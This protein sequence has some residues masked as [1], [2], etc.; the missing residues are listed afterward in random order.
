MAVTEDWELAILEVVKGEAAREMALE[1]NQFN[2]PPAEGMQY[3]AFKS[4]IRYIGTEDRP[5]GVDDS[6]FRATGSANIRYPMPSV[7]DPS[8]ALDAYLYPGGEYEG[9][10]IQQ[11]AKDETDLMVIFEPT[12]S[13]D[14]SE[15][16]Y[17]ALEEGATLTVPAELA[18]IEPN[19]LGAD[20]ESAA[21]IGETVV[22]EDWEITIVESVRGDNAWAMVQN[23]NQFN[24]P[25][26][27]G[28]EYIA[29]K[30]HVRQIGTEDAYVNISDAEFSITGSEGTL[31]DLPPVVDPD[32]PLEASLFPNGVFEGWFVMQVTKGETDLVLI[33]EPLE[34]SNANKR[35]LRAEP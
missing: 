16:R 8:P 25:P 9:W 31:Y 29:I 34:L 32:P 22:S 27:D 7:V 35:F 21:P 23:A 1:E 30:A 26:E 15:R 17:M 4:H 18:N 12:W 3:I 5:E 6:F 14:D 10:V 28:M 13:F 19:N 2:D 33:F 20:L 24:D 11:A